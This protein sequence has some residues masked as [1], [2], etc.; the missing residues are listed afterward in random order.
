MYA[1]ASTRCL[2]ELGPDLDYFSD[3]LE[4]CSK[5]NRVVT[6]YPDERVYLLVAIDTETGEYA[7]MEE[8]DQMASALGLMRP[9]SFKTKDFGLKTLETVLQFVEEKS[10]SP[11]FPPVRFER[12]ANLAKHFS[13]AISRFGRLHSSHGMIFFTQDP[14]GFVVYWKNQPLCKLKNKMYS[15]KHPFHSLSLVAMKLNILE[16]FF[17]KTTD[18]VM[19]VLPQAIKDYLDELRQKVESETQTAMN[20]LDTMFDVSDEK[21]Q[22]LKSSPSEYV[23]R[24]KEVASDIWMQ[25][26]LLRSRE[27]LCGESSSLSDAEK[28]MHDRRSHFVDYL[29]KNWRSKL[30]FWKET[31]VPEIV[32]EEK[33]WGPGGKQMG[34][35][36]V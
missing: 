31:S 11:D 4:L 21:K 34:T 13:S 23:K 28:A 29:E 6:K 3:I 30:G 5:Q 15:A 17:E 32:A 22:S 33:E 35:Q 26:Y 16:R 36:D 27:W 7:T 24:A 19:D 2:R 10:R 18:D 14:E 12:A 9:K 8:T 25:G 1:N 20:L